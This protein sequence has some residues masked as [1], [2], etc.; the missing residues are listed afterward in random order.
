MKNISFWFHHWVLRRLQV[1]VSCPGKGFATKSTL[2]AKPKQPSKSSFKARCGSTRLQE[3]Q[4]QSGLCVALSKTIRSHSRGCGRGFIMPSVKNF[5]LSF[6]G[7]G[8]WIPPSP[9]GCFC[10]KIPAICIA[11]HIKNYTIQWITYRWF[12]VN[13]ELIWNEWWC[14]KG[15]LTQHARGSH[16]K[17][18]T[19]VSEQV[20][21]SICV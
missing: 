11:H 21:F 12:K 9:G 5:L 13:R 19:T 2:C 8:E 15:S 6:P 7:C 17:P 4:G 16:F 14:S 10:Y 18:S 3:N 20:E 1:P